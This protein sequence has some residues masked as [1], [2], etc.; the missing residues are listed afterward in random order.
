M[1]KGEFKVYA[2]V[3][4]IKLKCKKIIVRGVCCT[5]YIVKNV[6]HL[7]CLNIKVKLL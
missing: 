6:F 4:L 2:A 5:K 1:S 3:C 7:Y